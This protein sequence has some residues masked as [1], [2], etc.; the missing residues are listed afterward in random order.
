MVFR[1]I[2]CKVFILSI[3]DLDNLHLKKSR[4]KPTYIYMPHSLISLT[5]GY[6]EKA[7]INYDILVCA[8]KYQYS[9]AE[10]FEKIYNFKYKNL[11]TCG[12]FK[13]EFI[14][15]HYKPIEKMQ[16]A[17]IA[18][19]WGNYGIIETMKIFKIIKILIQRKIKVILQP[20]PETLKKHSK[21]IRKIKSLYSNN[22]YF[23]LNLDLS[24]L[25]PIYRSHF[26][27]SDWSGIIFEYNI[28][29]QKPIILFNTNP[30][31]NNK[32]YKKYEIEP[33]EFIARKSLATCINNTSELDKAIRNLSNYPTY[34]KAQF[35]YNISNLTKLIKSNLA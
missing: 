31:I 3:T 20:H 8:N 6:N 32:N 17:L 27:I 14:K 7:F 28:A 18:P 5:A 35:R 26:L 1:N 15:K 4:F 33:I 12:Y 2:N 16:S 13:N 10:L 30:K 19:T 9:E 23:D 24:D 25:N 21:I 29:L 22:S 11:L 34:K